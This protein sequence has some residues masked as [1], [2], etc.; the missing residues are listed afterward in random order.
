MGIVTQPLLVSTFQQLDMRFQRGYTGRKQ[1][2]QQFSDIVPSSTKQNVYSWMAELPGLRKWTGPK[3]V[4]NLSTR[5]VA[6]VN[7]DYEDTYELDR[8]DIEDDIAGNYANR[9]Q[10]MGDAASRWPDDLMTDVVKAGTTALAFDGQFFFD[11]DHPVDMDDSGAGVY[12]NLLTSKPLTQANFNAAYAAMQS[13]VGES[14]KP[15]EVTPTIL[16]VQPAQRE[17]ALEITKG[18]L[19]AQL[20]KN[21]AG[22]ENVGASAASNV[23]VGEV[24]PLIN[25]RLVG[26]TTGAWYLLSTDRMKPFIFQQREPVHPV[27][28]ID[29][30][31]PT[32]FNQRKWTR[33]VEARGAG[34]YALPFLA[35]KC[36]P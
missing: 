15:L 12:A 33:G 28:M 20:A 25:P 9:E 10:L 30:Q 19:I 11:T 29:P 8:N 35:I 5:A 22:S 7:D 13:F 27:Q 1:Y 26:D 36:T 16:M 6:L 21:V 32:V 17:I 18:G 34:G 2:Y 23:N 4:R 3:L 31:N 24:T 14:G